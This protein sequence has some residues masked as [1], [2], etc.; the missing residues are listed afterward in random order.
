METRNRSQMKGVESLLLAVL[1][2]VIACGFA[3]TRYGQPGFDEH[4]LLWFRVSGETGRL[5]GPE[6]AGSF[7]HGLSW[8]GNTVPRLVLAGCG[9]MGLVLLHRWRSALFVAGVLSSGI[10]LSN[11]LKYWIGRPRPHLVAHLD[12]VSTASFPSGH[13]LN[14]TL[15][16]LLLALILTRF[17]HSRS[18]R[19]M[20]YAIASG[21]ALLTGISRI[22]LGVHYPSDVM[23]GWMI[24]GAWM[25]LWVAVV[26]TGLLDENGR[27]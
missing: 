11:A 26:G 18:A 6:W 8:L 24:G 9:M 19:W 27:S 22:A 2:A 15:F 16:Y 23:A 1:I 10:V 13:A 12:S 4:L 21:L 5:A 3:L 14:S 7:W 17:I 25:G 20:L